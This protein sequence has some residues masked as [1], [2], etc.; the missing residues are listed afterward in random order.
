MYPETAP[1]LDRHRPPYFK[2]KDLRVLHQRCVE[3][4]NKEGMALV[5]AVAA[6]YEGSLWRVKKKELEAERDLLH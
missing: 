5:K 6:A 1:S 2:F 4:E 3:L